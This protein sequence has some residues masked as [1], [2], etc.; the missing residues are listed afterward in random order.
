MDTQEAILVP[1]CIA[2]TTVDAINDMYD[3]ITQRAYEIFLARGGVGTLDIEDW[4]R[5]EQELLFKP[6]TRVEQ[7][8]HGITVTIR[9]GQAIPTDLQVLITSDAM[10]IQAEDASTNKTVFRSVEFPRRID[11]NKAAAVYR[12]G[13]LILT[14]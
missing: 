11:T 7:T 3:Q 14:A 12:N 1:L 10:I 4:L 5:A 9:I 6:E 8:D 2:D 13:C